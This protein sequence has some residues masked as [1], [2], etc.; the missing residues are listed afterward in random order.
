[1]TSPR[2]SSARSV[3]SETRRPLRAHDL[4]ATFVTVALA[5]GKGKTETWVSDRTGHTSSAM[6]SRHRRKARTWTGLAL[7]ALDPLD[8]AIPELSPVPQD[9]PG[10]DRSR[11]TSDDPDRENRE[12]TTIPEET[13]PAR[14]AEGS[15]AARHRGSS[16]LP[17]TDSEKQ[18]LH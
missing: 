14:E 7:G 1:M 5:C 15:A 13:R 11:S 16:P 17:S 8:T 6:I 4:R 2:A 10:D 18:A 3:R 12:G 9:C